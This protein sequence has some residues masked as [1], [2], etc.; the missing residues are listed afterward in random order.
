VDLNLV[1]EIPSKFPLHPGLGII[2]LCP[3]CCK[4]SVPDT[5]EALNMEKVK[6][7]GKPW[8]NEPLYASRL[9]KP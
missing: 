2:V 5:G 9:V 3:V 1:R 8:K 7:G 6:K 4:S